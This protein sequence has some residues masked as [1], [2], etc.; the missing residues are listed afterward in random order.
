MIC[1]KTI[2]QL[3]NSSDITEYPFKLK[4]FKITSHLCR[5][6]AT[7]E[8]D[9]FVRN[10]LEIQA[11]YLQDSNCNMTCATNVKD[12]LVLAVIFSQLK[13]LKKLKLNA[14]LLPKEPE[15]YNHLE[16]LESLTELEVSHSF[17]NEFAV[18]SVLK[19][20]PNLEILS[21]VECDKTPNIM[22]FIAVKTLKLQNLHIMKLNKKSCVV[23]LNL[24]HLHVEFPEN[25]ETLHNFL[26]RNPSVTN[27][28]INLDDNIDVITVVDGLMGRTSINHLKCKGNYKILKALFGKIKTDSKN[29]HSIELTVTIEGASS[30]T[31]AFNFPENIN[32][33]LPK[34]VPQPKPRIEITH[35]FEIEDPYY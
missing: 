20:L 24:K 35:N 21:A 31:I 17:P 19:N 34:N 30:P 1:H 3:E 32:C 22:S 16:L 9:V 14:A 29:L 11:N 8:D 23:F 13:C 7:N 18:K 15:F 5:Y 12:A 10:F 6:Y 33:N 2:L 28:S 26:N 4:K 25:F 27:L